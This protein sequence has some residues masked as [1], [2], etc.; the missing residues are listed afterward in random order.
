[1][2]RMSVCI[3][4]LE[5]ASLDWLMYFETPQRMSRQEYLRFV[6][7]NPDLRIERNSRGDVIVMPPA[8]SRTGSQNMAIGRQLANWSVRDGRGTAFDSSAGFDL[9]NSSNR[10]PDVSWVLNSRLDALTPEQKMDYFPLCPDFVIE[11]RS[12]SD[13]LS[14]L[15]EKMLEYLE[16]GARL[17]WLIDP[18]E[19]K[20][21]TYRPRAAVQVLDKPST[22]SGDPELSGFVLDLAAIWQSE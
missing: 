17:G 3:E 7:A 13:R 11:L 12:T 1:M 8:H 15:Q 21:H 18:I 4:P 14:R 16:N 22:V 10:S 5:S 19:Q 9:P 2:A 20:V 6:H